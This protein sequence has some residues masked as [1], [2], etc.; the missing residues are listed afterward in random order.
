MEKMENI[1]LT[2][3]QLAERL[4]IH[5]STVD[6]LRKVKGMPGGATRRLGLIGRPRWHYHVDEVESWIKQ[7]AFSQYM[8]DR[9]F[10]KP[11]IITRRR[12]KEVWLESAEIARLLGIRK[13]SV[14]DWAGDPDPPEFRIEGT[15]KRR[16]VYYKLRVTLT[17][18][19]ENK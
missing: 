19:T 9:M 8:Q 11:K 13:R 4:G 10:D 14:R 3:E 2:T 15:Q 1:L 7:N 12:I 18:E 17:W 6:F 16:K 5:V